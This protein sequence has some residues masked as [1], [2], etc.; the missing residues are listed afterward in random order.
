M[1]KKVKKILHHTYLEF[2]VS[3]YL[4][5][6]VYFISYILLKYTTQYLIDKS[7]RINHKIESLNISIMEVKK[8]YSKKSGEQEIEQKN[9]KHQINSEVLKSN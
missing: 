7:D 3:S 6:L 8:E 1:I 9:S 2:K 5:F 4:F